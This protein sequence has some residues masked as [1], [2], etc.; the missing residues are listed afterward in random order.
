M[1]KPD[2]LVPA[3]VNLQKL[4]WF[5]MNARLLRDSRFA[6]RA[7]DA[8]FK[9]GVL[10]WC[11]A[12]HQL[13]AASLPNDDEELAW[14]VNRELDR[15]LEIKEWALHKW[16]E[17]SDGRLYH[18]VLAKEALKSWDQRL[19][20]L[21]KQYKDRLRKQDKTLKPIPYAKW[22]DRIISGQINIDSNTDDSVLEI[23]AD[24]D[25]E[26]AGEAAAKSTGNPVEFQTGQG[27]DGTGQKVNP[28]PRPDASRPD[29]GA[30][31]A[32]DVPTP[33]NP[34]ATPALV[35][36]REPTDDELARWMFATI[37]KINP[38]HK[39]PNFTRW[40]DD[41]RLMREQDKRTPAAIVQLFE[42]VMKD[43]FWRG[44]VLSPAKLREQYDQLT[45]K[46]SSAIG[47]AAVASADRESEA[48]M[49]E[50]F[51]NLFNAQG[52]PHGPDAVDVEAKRVA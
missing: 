10:L 38:Q 27:P 4:D 52:E 51:P 42:W 6:A 36:S 45:I 49:R 1:T 39:E 24:D 46:R 50:I 17:C 5:P 30:G 25:D 16:V 21:Y 3:Y 12:W 20:H 32:D 41:F 44:N 43:T 47:S 8:A 14:L 9:A 19:L 29:G 23:G 31:R 11:A 13:P 33:L 28:N 34:P 22:K 40:A 7:P 15:F 37:Q 35:A 26:S 48:S 18:P 2:P